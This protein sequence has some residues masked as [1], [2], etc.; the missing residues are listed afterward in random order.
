MNYKKF[1]LAILIAGAVYVA[2]AAAV[3][4]NYSTDPAPVRPDVNA[5]TPWGIDWGVG[6]AC[7]KSS[8]SSPSFS[9]IKVSPQ[10]LE[11]FKKTL[12]ASRSN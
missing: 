2:G 6:A 1:S 4:G 3:V 11:L 7:Y 9:C 5:L 8:A 12:E 10:E